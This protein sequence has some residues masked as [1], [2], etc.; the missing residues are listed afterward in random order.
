MWG[1][2]AF[3]E[4]RRLLP[5]THVVARQ[6][7]LDGLAIVLDDGA[8]HARGAGRHRAAPTPSR[9]TS[10][11]PS[12]RARRARP[13]RLA[14]ARRP[15]R[16]AHLGAPA[17]SAPR[18]STRPSSRS[19]AP[20][21]S[22]TSSARRDAGC[23][24]RPTTPR[25]AWLRSRRP[26]SRR[27]SRLPRQ[28]PP[29]LR[30][31][32]RRRRARPP[33]PRRHGFDVVLV[34]AREQDE[35]DWRHRGLA[36]VPVHGPG[37]RA[38]AERFDVAVATWWETTYALFELDAERYA[39][40]VQSL[41]DRFYRAD[42]PE[43]LAAAL[44][45]DLP[46]ALVTEARWIADTLEAMRPGMRVHYVR[47]G[48][49]KDLF[50]GPPE[51]APLSAGGTAADPRR[52]QPRRLVQGRGRRAGGH[53]RHVGGPPRDARNARRRGACRVT[54]R[55]R[56]RAGLARRDG[57]RCTR[58]PTWCSSSRALRACTALRWRA[59][60]WAPRR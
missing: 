59:S 31:R 58:S 3:E 35:P 17:R 9:R 23:G 50:A 33:A 36:D 24:H 30:G 38:R 43:R 52:G 11:P 45:H 25:A 53:R 15:R 21:W 26:P 13:A 22:S 14:T 37:P 18:R 41:E 39:F 5:P 7:P 44:T 34:L 27:E 29:A 49:A 8:E 20:M 19:S 2:G 42:E 10:W 54:G 28:R 48:I 47:N 12:A 1:E 56:A 16:P 6:V 32:R 60:T 55:P 40:F 57:R 4:L 46:V 51:P